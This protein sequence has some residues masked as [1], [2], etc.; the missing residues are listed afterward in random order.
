MNKIRQIIFQFLPILL[1]FLF[2]KYPQKFAELSESGLGRLFAIIVIIFY[3]SIDRTY[4]LLVCLLIIAYY[5]SDF[6]ENF[7]DDEGTEQEGESKGNAKRSK[8][9]DD[10]G[11]D[12]EKEGGKGKGGKND[13]KDKKDKKGKKGRRGRKD[14]GEEDEE[15]EEDEEDESGDLEE[16]VTTV[17]KAPEIP[18]DGNIMYAPDLETSQEGFEELRDVYPTQDPGKI[19]LEPRDRLCKVHCK[20]GHLIHKGQIIKPEM[21]EHVYP[22][23]VSKDR[24]NICDPSCKFK[25]VENRFIGK[26]Q[27]K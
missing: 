4:G 22:N 14:E 5:Q 17:S 6:V 10:N 21:T 16:S 3:V 8:N 26:T 19:A 1:V 7:T 11:K 12:D 2:L 18:K 23:I 9:K 13:K 25:V 27:E 15:N 20:N 24:C